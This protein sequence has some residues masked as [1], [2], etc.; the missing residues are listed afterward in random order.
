MAAP[1]RGGTVSLSIGTDSMVMI[2]GAM[3]VSV[4]ASDR[5]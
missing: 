4:Q 3:K 2:V 1:C 5:R